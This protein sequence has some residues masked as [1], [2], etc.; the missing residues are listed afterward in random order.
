ME[1]AEKESLAR[2]FKRAWN[3]NPEF[4][5]LYTSLRR[6]GYVITKIVIEPRM[7]F[8]SVADYED[9]NGKGWKKKPY[10]VTVT[11]LGESLQQTKINFFASVPEDYLKQV[12]DHLV[13]SSQTT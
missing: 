10:D 8:P 5:A 9:Q 11:F 2:M 12:H 6:Q 7:S 4:D 1:K 3:E 13:L